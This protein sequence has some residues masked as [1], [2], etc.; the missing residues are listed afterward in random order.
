[1]AQISAIQPDIVIVLRGGNDLGRTCSPTPQSV[2]S[3]LCVFADELL[4]RGVKQECLCQIERR[5]RWRHFDFENGSASLSGSGNFS[6][7]NGM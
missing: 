5:R 7:Q 3:R 1:M 2:G 6:A 4:A